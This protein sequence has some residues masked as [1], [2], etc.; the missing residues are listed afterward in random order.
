MTYSRRR[1][2]QWAASM[3]ALAVAGPKGTRIVQVAGV[4]AIARA[5]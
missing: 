4:A 2:M 5:S 3:S 1:F